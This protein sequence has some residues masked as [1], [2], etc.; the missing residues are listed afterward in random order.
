[1]F[2]WLLENSLRNRLLVIISDDNVF[3][4]VNFIELVIKRVLIPIAD[5]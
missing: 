3:N 2:K 5:L 4:V 1:M